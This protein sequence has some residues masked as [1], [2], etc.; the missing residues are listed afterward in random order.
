MEMLSPSTNGG[1]KGG[2]PTPVRVALKETKGPSRGVESSQ[3]R[4]A[5]PVPGFQPAA[6]EEPANCPRE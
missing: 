3:P 6:T 4:R 5:L 2:C 1:M